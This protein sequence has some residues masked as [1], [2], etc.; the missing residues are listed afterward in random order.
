MK[1]LAST[2]AGSWYPAAPSEIHALADRWERD[3]P[4][5][6]SPLPPPPNV[7]V[8][9]HAGWAYSGPT[10]WQA[11]RL[12]RGAPYRRAVILAPCH[13]AHVSNRLVAPE[14]DSLST[15]LG[16]LPVDR[17]WLDRLSLLAPVVRHDR[18]HAAEHAAQ[19]LY[20]LLQLVLPGPFSL[21]PLVAGDFDPDQL[22]M[23]ARALAALLSPDTLLVVSSDFTHYGTDFDYAPHGTASSPRVRDL[24]AAAD[25]DAIDRIAARDPDGFAASLRRTGATICGAVPIELAL[26]ALPPS[27]TLRLLRYATSADPDGDYSRF[28]C[29]AALAGRADWPPPP[30][31]TLSPDDRAFLLRLARASL[32]QAVQTGHPLPP[33]RDIPDSPALRESRGAFVTL[34]RRDDGD[35]RGCIGEILPRRPLPEAVAAL[36]ADS[37]LHDPRFYPVTPG[38]LPTLRVEIS[39]LTPPSPVPSWQSIVLGRDGMTLEKNGRF[40]VFLPQVA[41]EQAWD[42]PTTLTHLS[43]KAGLPPDAWQT[44]ATFETFQAEVFHE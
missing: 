15:P 43:R 39:A 2:I 12:L 32:E 35:L 7:L 21:V 5:L 36:A 16:V 42:L 24:V 20:P 27:A 40:A 8:L 3:S 17:D 23:S 22:A 34:T 25:A 31:S 14:S 11:V 44:G 28:V 41:P 4:P 26:R 37:A 6:P 33:P 38:E 18:L 9:P 30:P 10:A 29:Y 1:P 19:I 13:C